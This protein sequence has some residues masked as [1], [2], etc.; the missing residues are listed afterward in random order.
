MTAKPSRASRNG[1]D[2]LAN[3]FPTEATRTSPA[4]AE[5]HQKALGYLKP[6]ERALL[7]RFFKPDGTRI[8]SVEASGAASSALHRR[9]TVFEL[10]M[11][12]ARRETQQ[13]TI[14]TFIDNLPLSRD[15]KRVLSLVEFLA[16]QKLRDCCAKNLYL[17]VMLDLAEGT[18]SN[19]IA[20]LL[21]QG[22][23][24]EKSG[25]DG[26]SR[27]LILNP[28]KF[29]HLE[30]SREPDSR[31]A[32]EARPPMDAASIADGSCIHSQLTLP[33]SKMEA[34]SILNGRGK[35]DNP[36]Q[37]PVDSG[38]TTDLDTAEPGDNLEDN[39][40]DIPDARAAA[41]PAAGKVVVKSSVSCGGASPPDPTRGQAPWTPILPTAGF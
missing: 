38:L 24:I 27:H 34:A 17:A 30:P 18:V 3:L 14:P 7:K 9:N 36:P 23:I 11:E 31:G 33:P 12:K 37:P 41:R 13:T 39:P 28:A 19:I 32:H 25:F 10:L 1:R 22:Y 5:L 21:K 2:P 16:R 40:H 26:R 29:P 8:K 35:T 6:K 15:Q 4:T 20:L